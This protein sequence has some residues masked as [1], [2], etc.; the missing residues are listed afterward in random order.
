[1]PVRERRVDRAR[2]RA[3][4]AIRRLGEELR[5][6]RLSSGWSQEELGSIV[7]ISSS[8][9]SRIELGQARRVPYRT[10]ALVGAVLGLDVPLRSFPREDPLRDAGQ[11]ALLAR[12]RARFPGLRHAVEVPLGLPGDR[13]A[14][15]AV[16]FGREWSI[17]VEAETRLRDIQAL[18]RRL[19]LKLR[20]ARRDR[21]VLLVGDTRHNRQVLRLASESLRTAFPVRGPDAVGD[22]AQGRCPT[23]STIIVL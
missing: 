14:W 9:V 8:E 20:D 21:V 2:Y 22:L 23:G 16:V 19:G 4:Q 12:F 5:E 6:A 13:R 7:G 11:L 1:M 15:D 10:L 3:D 17:P 18:E